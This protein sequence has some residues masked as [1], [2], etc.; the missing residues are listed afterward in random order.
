MPYAGKYHK[1][2]LMEEIGIPTNVESVVNVRGQYVKI[3]D[4]DTGGSFKIS[5]ET[6]AKLSQLANERPE[7]K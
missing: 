7:E 3:V 2:N 1:E 6:I 4:R 5:F